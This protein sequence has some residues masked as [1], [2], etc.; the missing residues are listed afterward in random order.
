MTETISSDTTNIMNRKAQ[1]IISHFIYVDVE[2]SYFSFM[3][4]HYDINSVV[5]FVD[6]AIRK[7]ILCIRPTRKTV[8]FTEE[9]QVSV[10]CYL[11]IGKKN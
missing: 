11:V 5:C 7:M 10:L 6:Y 8:I 3:I 2:V 4:M 9:I 1:Y